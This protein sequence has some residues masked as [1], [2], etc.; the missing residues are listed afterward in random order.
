[1]KKKVIFLAV[2][3]VLLVI[4]SSAQHLIGFHKDDIMAYMKENKKN[5]KLNTST[6]N[7]SYKYL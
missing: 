3:S 2:F 4:N 6:V 1:M 5:F 7:K